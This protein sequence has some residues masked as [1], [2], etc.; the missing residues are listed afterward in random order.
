MTEKIHA[1]TVL[2]VRK[3]PQVAM[4]SDGQVTLGNTVVKATAK[5][6]RKMAEGRVL[7]GFAGS[8]ADGIALFERLEAKLKEHNQQLLRAAVEL[9]KD[10]R[11]DRALRRLEAMIIV[12]DRERTL[13]LSGGGD[14]I[15]PENGIA[16]IGSGG[17]FALAAA[18]ALVDATDL[19]AREISERALRIAGEICIY[20][21]TQL[22]FEEL[23]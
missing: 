18:R 22:C 19:S 6:V 7:G 12:A 23:S 13:I 10:W 9:A 17:P 15:E 3:G 20:T 5:K 14:V 2:C 8:A 4:A 21:N 1:T 16:A 11:T